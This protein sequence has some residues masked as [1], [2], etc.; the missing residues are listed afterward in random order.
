LVLTFLL[1]FS[2]IGGFILSREII[3]LL[4]QRGAF[5]IQD[6]Q[7]TTLVLQMYMIGLVPFGLQKLLLLWIYAKQMQMR[8]AKIA[9]ISLITYTILALAFISPLGV[10]GLALASTIGGV[11]GFG[12]SIKAFG[13]EN[14]LDILRSKN[15]V[16]LVIG[17]ILLTILLTIFKD[18]IDVYI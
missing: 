10:S 7:N 11:V 6:T 18:F 12:L 3:W 17:S 16:Y 15:L 8:A 9:T 14:F 1:S 2:A 4:F 5:S 13:V